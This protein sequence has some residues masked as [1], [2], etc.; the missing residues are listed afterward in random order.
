MMILGIGTDLLFCPRIEKLYLRFGQ[1]FLNRV[2]TEKEQERCDE[3]HNRF[4]SYGKVFAAKEAVIKAVS[5]LQGASWTEIE[6]SNDLFGKPHV[7]LHGI[8]QERMKELLPKGSQARIELSI[9]DEPPYAQAFA[10]FF[11]V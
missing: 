10:L 8:A 4:E 2:F 1:R 7:H 5:R 3:R 11:V 6:I 9:T